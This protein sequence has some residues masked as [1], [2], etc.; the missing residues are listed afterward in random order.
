MNKEFMRRTIKSHELKMYSIPQA[1][2]WLEEFNQRPVTWQ[3]AES[4]AKHSSFFEER[5]ILVAPGWVN[6]PPDAAFEKSFDT[7]LSIQ[8]HDVERVNKLADWIAGLDSVKSKTFDEKIAL[9][10]LKLKLWK[11]MQKIRRN[12]NDSEGN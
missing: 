8:K 12:G 5:N 6:Y 9:L 1:T 2:A 11:A 3:K 10:E 7:W 4:L